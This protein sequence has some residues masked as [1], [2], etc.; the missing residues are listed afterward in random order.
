[1]SNLSDDEKVM[2]TL[3]FRLEFIPLLL[4]SLVL[5]IGAA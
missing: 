2:Y 4:P 1:M 3:L 5:G